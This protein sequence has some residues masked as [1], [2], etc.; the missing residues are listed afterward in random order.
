[1]HNSVHVHEQNPLIRD[2][3]TLD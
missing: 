1:V 2:E 3:F